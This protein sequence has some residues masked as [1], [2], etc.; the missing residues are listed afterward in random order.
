MTTVCLD[1]IIDI[2]DFCV[3]TYNKHL[4]LK[5]IIDYYG[6]N[7]YAN[8]PKKF[9]KMIIKT[10]YLYALKY[11][12]EQ[13][14]EICIFAVQQNGLILKY[15]KEQTEEICIYAVQQNGNALKYVKEQFQTEIMCIT[16]VRKNGNILKYVKKQ[17]HNICLAAVKQN[18]R[19]YL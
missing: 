11:V 3:N 6:D 16:A 19:K 8:Y 10:K 18:Y 7:L 12:K 4:I 1:N 2:Y 15:A 9:N 5:S 14:E 13:T 17:T